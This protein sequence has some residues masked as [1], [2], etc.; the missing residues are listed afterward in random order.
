MRAAKDKNQGGQYID[1]YHLCID[2]ATCVPLYTA[3]PVSGHTQTQA[4]ICR[5]LNI[6][7]GGVRT[8]RPYWSPQRRTVVESFVLDCL[9]AE[10][11]PLHVFMHRRKPI[12]LMV[13]TLLYQ[14]NCPAS[15]IYPHSIR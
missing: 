3:V 9:E 10:S 13:T 6:E 11:H 2:T 12:H 7:A 15:K 14:Y 8:F 4:I 5:D 1:I